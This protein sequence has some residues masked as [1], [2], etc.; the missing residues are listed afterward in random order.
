[1]FHLKKIANASTVGS[2]SQLKIYVLLDIKYDR[3]KLYKKEQSGRLEK[4]I[5]DDATIWPHNPPYLFL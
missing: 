1:M 4:N 2:L 5:G 3:H